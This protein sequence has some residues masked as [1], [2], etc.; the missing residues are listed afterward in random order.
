[1]PELEGIKSEVHSL[2]KTIAGLQPMVKDVHTQMPRILEALETL[3][4]VTVKLENN[5]EDHKRLHYRIT[6]V[7]TAHEELA[8]RHEDLAG[9]F[10]ALE[11]EHL[12]CITT[13]QVERKVERC[14]WWS[15]A[16]SKALEKAVEI[17]TLAII[18]FTAWMVLT[19][20]KE[21][22]KTAPIVT[23]AAAVKV[24]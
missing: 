9:K 8:E 5:T 11:K 3:A 16:K 13:R 22:P 4:K 7:K 14:S 24:K 20:L 10:D 15:K 19:H 18:G 2:N 23:P 12:V 1:M 21:Y 17:V 6:E